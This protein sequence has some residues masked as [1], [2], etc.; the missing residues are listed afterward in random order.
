MI[1]D[2]TFK[3]AK[4][5]TAGK[6]KMAT[7]LIRDVFGVGKLHKST[8]EIPNKGSQANKKRGTKGIMNR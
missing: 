3:T 1:L 8:A 5:K 2:E 4:L 7:P 6:K